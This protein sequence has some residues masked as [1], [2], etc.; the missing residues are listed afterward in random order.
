MLRGCQR[1]ADRGQVVVEAHR[2]AGLRAVDPGVLVEE[3]GA[4]TQALVKAADHRAVAGHTRHAG[5]HVDDGVGAADGGVDL[6]VVGNQQRR[7]G[8]RVPQRGRAVGGGRE[9]ERGRVVGGQA[10]DRA[11]GCPDAVVA[12]PL[13]LDGDDR[14]GARFH[15]ARAAGHIAAAVPGPDRAGGGVGG[16]ARNHRAVP[17]DGQRAARLRAAGRVEVHHRAVAV[18]DRV[19]GRAR[20]ARGVEVGAAHHRAAVAGDGRRVALLLEAGAAHGGV[21]VEAEAAQRGPGAGGGVVGGGLAEAVGSGRVA[22][23][24]AAVGRDARATGKALRGGIATDADQVAQGRRQ[25][26]IAGRPQVGDAG[27]ALG[28]DAHQAC[29]DGRRVHVEYVVGMGG[30]AGGQ[31]QGGQREAAM[32]AGRR[33]GVQLQE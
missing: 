22:V 5:L 7:I 9:A 4:A 33:H 14:A 19:R 15:D 8:L 1:Q 24:Q 10:V 11:A 20:G 13:G 3:A 12:E 17:A 6:V 32:E 28:A 30:A 27:A 31:G 25:I 16:I 26:G 18:D 2:H 21:A 23:D 29:V